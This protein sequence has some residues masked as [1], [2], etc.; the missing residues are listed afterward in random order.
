MTGTAIELFNI[1]KVVTGCNGRGEVETGWIA[2]RE[3]KNG[4]RQGKEELN[5]LEQRLM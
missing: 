3:P 1:H 2:R 5:Q 4:K